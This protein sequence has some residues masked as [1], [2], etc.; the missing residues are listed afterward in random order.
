MAP[1]VQGWAL[2]VLLMLPRG[3]GGPVPPE[4]LAAVSGFSAPWLAC[5]HICQ[6]PRRGAGGGLPPR[7]SWPITPKRASG[8]G[9]LAPS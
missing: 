2:T 5:P 6:R 4:G 1:G 3:L 7:P 9:S 8:T